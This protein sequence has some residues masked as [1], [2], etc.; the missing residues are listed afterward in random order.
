MRAGA[1]TR[2]RRVRSGASSHGKGKEVM[3]SSA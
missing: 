2:P 3:S 1:A